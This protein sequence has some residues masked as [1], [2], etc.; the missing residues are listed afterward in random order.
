M[1]KPGEP[2]TMAWTCW[3]CCLLGMEVVLFVFMLVKCPKMKMFENLKKIIEKSVNFETCFKQNLGCCYKMLIPLNIFVD[4]PRWSIFNLSSSQTKHQIIVYTRLASLWL[5]Y[6][7]VTHF[8]SVIYRGELTQLL[9]RL[10]AH[11]AT[12]FAKSVF[13]A[14]NLVWQTTW[15]MKKHLVV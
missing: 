15:A 1:G 4:D 6:N 5:G 13:T 8:C 7:P 9:A 11:L 3:L 10:G 14:R 12:S 2:T